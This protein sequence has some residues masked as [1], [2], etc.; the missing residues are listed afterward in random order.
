MKTASGLIVEKREDGDIVFM[1]ET[2]ESKIFISE[3]E[4]QKIAEIM[5]DE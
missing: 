2:T 4:L 1:N 5:V 3:P